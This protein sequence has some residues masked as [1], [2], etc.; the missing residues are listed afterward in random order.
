M[1]TSSCSNILTFSQHVTL[2]LPLRLLIP[3]SLQ[4]HSHFFFSNMTPA[5]VLMKALPHHAGPDASASSLNGIQF[6]FLVG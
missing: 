1:D 4:V 2:I 6:S 3:I 5:I